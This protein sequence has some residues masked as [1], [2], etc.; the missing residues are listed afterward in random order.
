MGSGT[1]ASLTATIATPLTNG[2]NI[3]GN[4]T[5]TID[6]VS[7]N[8]SAPTP[9]ALTATIASTLTNGTNISGSSTLTFNTT[10]SV[11]FDASA[12]TTATPLVATIAS[13][14]TNG[15]N[16]SGSSTL[17]IDGV[18]FNASPP[19]SST[20]SVAV[21]AAYCIPPNAGVTINSVG[22]TTNGTATKGTITINSDPSGSNTIT[23][24]NGS[25]SSNP[26]T[27]VYVWHGTCGTDTYCVTHTG[28]TTL[29]ALNLAGAI[30]GSCDGAAC[31]ANPYVTATSSTNVVTVTS[32][33]AG[34]GALSLSDTSGL[35]IS[36]NTSSSAGTTGST[37]VANFAIGATNTATASNMA[38]AI[39]NETATD[40]VTASAA[41]GTVTLTGK[42]PG[43]TDNVTVALDGA[44][45]GITVSGMTGGTN[46][47]TSGTSSNPETFAYWS[48]AA[49][50]SSSVLASTIAT[51]VGTT[52]ATTS[53]IL[54]AT[55]NSPVSDDITFAAKNPGTG[56]NVSVTPASFTAF[57]GGSLT[58]GTNG[59]TNTA[60]NPETFAY[61]S[62]SAPVSNST[63]ASTIQGL[64][65]ANATL[66]AAMT[67]TANSP[68]GGNVLFDAVVP[69]TGAEWR[70][71]G[72]SG[73]FHCVYRR[74][75]DRRHQRHDLRD[76]L[77]SGDFR[78]LVRQCTCKLVDAGLD[79]RDPGGHH[80]HHDQRNPD[81]DRELATYK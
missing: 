61:W 54:T 66:T 31:S 68:A 51:L 34:T 70:L 36:L 43:T 39:G 24:G 47:T 46:G 16:I 44:P 56:A 48:G 55:P 23:I 79:D 42:N 71:Y 75:V 73:Q 65:A 25:S 3:S 77:E 4:S 21:A 37:S 41:G 27:I 50:V 69:G 63:L 5:L 6:G 8:A 60:S 64:V 10:P 45:T 67:A 59:T 58:G 30:N 18:N 57:T 11:T 72:H 81:G 29:D 78:L 33:C 62:G 7:F 53:A 14:L 28:T 1:T 20:G 80:Q 32:R 35:S 49:P 13:T 17:A 38:T 76:E 22:I 40:D 15:T 26:G 52:N 2:T 74:D 12:P 19:T 9:A